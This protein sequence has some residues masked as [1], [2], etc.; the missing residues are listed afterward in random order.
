M[1]W[2]SQRKL[3]RA[4]WGILAVFSAAYSFSARHYLWNASIAFR[5]SDER[6][7]IALEGKNLEDERQ[8]VS[9]FGIGIVATA[10]YNPPRTWAV[11]V[12]YEF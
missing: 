11:S 5:S 10:G 6:W 3:R 7:R 9:T 12:G 8:P 1:Y 2:L 4:A